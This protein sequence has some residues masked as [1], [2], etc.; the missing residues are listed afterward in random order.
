MANSEMLGLEADD[1]QA[2]AVAEPKPQA[3]MT[4]AKVE[5]K[6]T[7]IMA[8][9]RGLKL[10]TLDDAWRFA[11]MVLSSRLAPSTFDS[12]EKILIAMQYG[13]EVGLTPM[14][15]LQSIAVINGRPSMWGDALPG[16]VWGSGSTRIGC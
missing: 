1:G 16:L 8:G 7:A 11:G 9:D 12:R 15:S 13:A 10:A 6:P 2:I 4:V 14:Q 3:V 5:S